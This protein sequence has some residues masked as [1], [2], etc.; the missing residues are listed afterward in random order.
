VVADSVIAARSPSEARGERLT[1]SGIVVAT[2]AYMSP[3]QR[4]GQWQLDGRSD[5]YSP[6][7]VAADDL[8]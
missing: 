7:A 2:P 8:P 5:V 1:G 6:A 4:T 3:Q